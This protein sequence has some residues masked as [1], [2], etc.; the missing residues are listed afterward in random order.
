MEGGKEEGVPPA[1]QMQTTDHG[2]VDH[3]WFV[4]HGLGTP[5]TLHHRGR[6]S[7]NLLIWV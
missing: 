6:L 5:A 3:Q 1:V 4:G 7:A 2:L